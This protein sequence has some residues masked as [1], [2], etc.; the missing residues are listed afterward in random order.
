MTARVRHSPTL[1]QHMPKPA[2][3]FRLEVP[4]TSFV[5]RCEQLTV[6]LRE[7]EK[8]A[9]RMKTDV[10]IYEGERLVKTVTPLA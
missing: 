9:L 3:P 8:L 7:A 1:R 5:Q 4:G 10:H 6:A 2:R